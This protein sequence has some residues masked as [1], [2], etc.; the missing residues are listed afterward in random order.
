MYHYR[1]SGLPNIYLSGGCREVQTAYGPSIVIEDVEG[2]HY[3]IAVMLVNERP[4]LTGPEVRFI[5]RYLEKTQAELGTLLGVEEQ[6]VRRWERLARVPKPADHAV[7][8]LFLNALRDRQQ[9][10]PDFEKL[11]AHAQANDE[12][13][14]QVSLRFRPRAQEKWKPEAVAA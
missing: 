6:S 2:L 13:H 7:R 9:R 12:A 8:L 14:P 10:V 5:R 11:I 4:H 3:A 1:E